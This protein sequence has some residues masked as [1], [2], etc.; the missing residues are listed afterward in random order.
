VAVR[1]RVAVEGAKG[2]STS[3][4]E[5]R[6]TLANGRQIAERVNLDVPAS[7]L[8]WQWGRLEAKFR[9]L[10]APVLG[11]SRAGELVEAVRTI[12]AARSVGDLVRLAAAA[13]VGAAR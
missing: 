8:D 11:A 13:P 7:D 3:G 12:D 2:G 4:T 9:G 6:L 5:V 1:D 10:A